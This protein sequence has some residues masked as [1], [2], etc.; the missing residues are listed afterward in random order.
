MAP[1]E[2]MGFPPGVAE[3]MIYQHYQKWKQEHERK[4]PSDPTIQDKWQRYEEEKKMAMQAAQ[5]KRET[6][7]TKEPKVQEVTEK[8]PVVAKKETKVFEPPTPNV[9][10]PESKPAE[11]KPEAPQKMVDISTYNGDATEKYKWSQA[12]NEVSVQIDLPENTKAKDLLVVFKS[13]YLKVQ[14]KNSDTPIVEGKLD[15]KI[16]VD[17]SFWTIEERKRLILTL[18]KAG[19]AIWKTVIQGDQEIDT[20]NVDNSKNLEDFD[21]ETQGHLRKVLYEQKRKQMGL[22]TTE[23]Q[24]QQDAMRKVWDAPNS[25]FK[26]QPYDPSVYGS[27]P[28]IPFNH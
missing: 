1:E 24:Q 20:K 5:A 15:S 22:P 16:K 23:E 17:D 10:A 12:F 6:E 7:P 27:G 9:K 26:G 2:K 28:Q 4:H 13:D 11:K 21:H 18:T 25:P 14:L 19:E 8:V 3:S